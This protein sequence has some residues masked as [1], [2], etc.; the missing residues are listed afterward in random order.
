MLHW[1][2]AGFVVVALVIGMGGAGFGVGY[3]AHREQLQPFFDLGE[4]I[5]IRGRRDLGLPTETHEMV[6]RLETT[7]LTM[8]GRVFLMPDQEFR[9]GGAL[10]NWDNDVIV[11]HSSG[12]IM[13]LDEDT[14]LEILD[15]P[16]PENN[17]E[18]YVELAASE[19][20]N[21]FPRA[22][23][24]R[25]ND[26]EFIDGPI[27][28]GL[29]LSYTYIDI[30][31]HCYRTRISQLPVLETITSIRDLRISES[32]WNLLFETSPCLPFN[33]EG[34]LVV[35]YMAGG[36]IAYSPPNL[37]YFGSGDYHMD[38]I[39]RPDA[40]IQEPNSDYGKVIEIDLSSA[41]AR[42]Y[43]VGH[44]NVQGVEIDALGRVWTTE[45]GMRGGD[46]L[47]LIR[48]QGNY[49]WPLENLGTLYSGVP[50]PTVGRIGRHE[51]YTAPIFA[52]LPSAAVSSLAL[53]EGFHETW[54]GDLLIGSLRNQTLYR[55][56]IREDRV[57]FMEEIPIGQ[58]IRDVMVVQPRMIVL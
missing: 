51:V 20:P 23:R 52:W 22:E 10:T 39:Y 18:A 12:K 37:L 56:R 41:A 44:R 32:D 36:R 57:V 21:Q 13:I 38:G 3:L 53:V 1:L 54:D 2:P 48:D 6:A 46:E 14:G 28:R 8:R 4:R 24:I 19:F 26:I 50:A 11:L 29:L 16:V 7:Y 34:E 47:N 30:Q 5:I 45:H 58:R 43:S 25:Y 49:G 17:L 9:A 15:L 27:F 55:A 33:S 35:G 40:G 42:H 31:D